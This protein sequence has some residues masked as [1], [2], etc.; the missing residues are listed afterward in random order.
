MSPLLAHARA[1]AIAYLALFIALSGTSYAATQLAANS[2]G[3]KQI[4][5]NAV[6]SAEVKNGKLLAKDF[7]A[8][9]LPAGAAGATGPAGSA[10]VARAR[11]TGD[12]IGSG[13]ASP[14]TLTGAGYTQAATELDQFFAVATI[15]IPE[16]VQCGANK[17]ATVSVKVDAFN[18]LNLSLNSD[19]FDDPVTV[20]LNLAPTGV[21]T[22]FEPGTATA[23]TVTATLVDACAGASHYHLRDL[24]IDV[25]GVH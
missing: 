1:N 9:Q 13:L 3:A 11:F 14:V 20:Q 15:D 25:V 7:K 18:V 8:G 21:R 2:V 17:Q 16:A 22:F 19:L 4:K 10:V 24:K 6:T 12:Q 5:S 23:H